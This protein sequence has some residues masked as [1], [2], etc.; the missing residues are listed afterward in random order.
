MY[1]RDVKI[2]LFVFDVTDIKSIKY[3]N[4]YKNEFYDKPNVKIIVLG[5]K[6]DLLTEEYKLEE[7]TSE[8]NKNFEDLL[9]TDQVHGLYFISAKDGNNFDK[10]LEHFYECA[11]TL[12]IEDVN[13]N[14]KISID[15]L[16]SDKNKDKDIIQQENIEETSYKCC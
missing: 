5:N 16:Y 11:K 10:F 4:K 7:L 9:L 13:V 8:V 6:T 1:F 12:P 2:V 14:L 3:I 15:N